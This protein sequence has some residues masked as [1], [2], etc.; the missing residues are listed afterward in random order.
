M[1]TTQTSDPQRRRI[2]AFAGAIVVMGPATAIGFPN[3][4]AELVVAYGP[5]PPLVAAVLLAALGGAVMM[6]A[7]RHRPG[8]APSEARARDADDRLRDCLAAG[9]DWIWELDDHDRF[10]AIE[11]LGGFAFVPVD[12]DRIGSGWRAL[13]FAAAAAP[14]L[15]ELEQ[16][17]ARRE[18]FRDIVLA[19]MDARGTLRHFAISGVAVFGPG[20]EFRGYR[21]I[22]RDVSA[23][24]RR[25]SLLIEARRRAEAA[26]EAKTTFVAQLSHELR[27]PLNAVIGFADVM[28]RQM[29]GPIGQ[30]RYLGYAEDIR[31]AGQHL[32][33]LIND[34]IDLARLESGQHALDESEF[35]LDAV[36]AEAMS[37]AR[38]RAEARG[39]ALESQL[40]VRPRLRADARAIRQMLINLLT[41]AVTFSRTG[42]RVVLV[43]RYA[44]DSAELE[45]AVRDFGAGIA[46]EDLARLG[47]PFVQTSA[48][49]AQGGGSGLGLAIVRRLVESH[50]GRLELAS[51]IGVGTVAKVVLPARRVVRRTPAPAPHPPQTAPTP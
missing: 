5:W 11:R 10:T 32:L 31:G 39:V 46:A 22:G 8:P 41:N 4:V 30:P 51:R 14:A 16:H 27:S 43:A 19:H 37:I 1:E 38:G 24:V 25:E 45:I 40:V 49:K 3:R 50:D 42:G 35:E 29:L 44:E 17:I 12:R 47:R 28:A 36:V 15:A 18:P 20:A 34:T 13:G 26:S 9:A 7:L 6:L 23:S 21:G 48:G 2:V 33:S